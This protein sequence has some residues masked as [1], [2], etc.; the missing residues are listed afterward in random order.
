MS[1]DSNNQGM[2]K[3]ESKDGEVFKVERGVATMSTVIANIL[4]DVPENED[5]IP[6]KEVDAKILAK[7]IEYCRYHYELRNTDQSHDEIQNWNK[8]FIKVDIPTL[9]KI[10]MAANFMDIKGLLDLGCFTVASKIRDRTPEEIRDVF[11]IK[12]DFSQEEEEDLKKENSWA[13]EV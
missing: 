10:I 1:N 11:G 13:E 12:N 8:E 4:Q 2:I 9:F 5:R 3:L 6:I 7:V